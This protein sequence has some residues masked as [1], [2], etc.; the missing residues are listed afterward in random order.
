MMKRDRSDWFSCMRCLSDHKEKV[1]QKN[2]LSLFVLIGS[3]VFPMGA[4]A[5]PSLTLITTVEDI[6]DGDIFYTAVAFEAPYRYTLI[7]SGDTYLSSITV[8]DSV[9]GVVGAV[10][11][12]V[13]P[14]E[15]N[16]LTATNFLVNASVTNMGVAVGNPTDS[17]GADLPA[18]PDVTDSDEA[19]VWIISPDITLIVTADDATQ[20]ETGYTISGSDV[21]Y[22]YTVINSGNTYLT[23][24]TVTD[25][26]VGVVGT[27]S[28]PVS[29][30]ATNVLLA[31][32]LNVTAAI[33]NL[34]VV[35]GHPTD[36]GGG[37]LYTDSGVVGDISDTDPAVV[38][39]ASPGLSLITTA[40]DAADGETEYI[41]SGSNVLYRYTVI[42]SGDTYLSSMSVTDSVVGVV[43][44]I[45][46]PVA[47]GSTNVLLATNLN[48]TASVTNQGVAIANPTDSGGVD[49]P[50]LP[51]VNDSDSAFVALASPALTLITTAGNAADGAT[52]YII[53]GS[54]VVY[55]Y[56]LIN[57]GDTYLSSMTVTDSVVGVVGSISGPVAPG[58]T[59]VLLATNLNV[60]AS[61]TNQ[62]VAIANP[63]DSGGV[64]LPS[65]TNV[66]AMDMAIVEFFWIDI[67]NANET[68]PF[69]ITDRV[70]GG[71]STNLIGTFVWTNVLTGVGGTLP[72]SS[73]WQIP[74]PVILA[75]GTN[76]IE[77]CGT[78][79]AGEQACDSV[80]IIRTSY[81]VFTNVTTNVNV[82]FISW[83]FSYV[84]GTFFG[85][86]EICNR[87]G[88]PKK[89]LE[90]YW[91]L[92]ESN[93]TEYLMAPDGIET[94]SG[95][96]YVDLSTQI[97]A[98]L[99]GIGNGDGYLD[100]DECVVVTNIEYYSRL[101]EEPTGLVWAI[102]AD[103]PI[104]NEDT[105]G[106]GMLDAWE[107]GHALNPYDPL[108][109]FEDPD[110]D[111]HDNWEEAISGTDPQNCESIF[112]IQKLTAASDR[113]VLRWNS[114][115]SR[116]YSVWGCSN[117]YDPVYSLLQNEIEATPPVNIW[118]NLL[119]CPD[120]RFF[121]IDVEH[122]E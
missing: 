53:S 23:S 4:V 79:A 76:V 96:P 85:T 19:I 39:L 73:S 110:Q 108:D 21:V 88:S 34:G 66:M 63:T 97:V 44:S 87:T 14:G 119:P 15:T 92:M 78:N 30:G 106:D 52:E 84:T 93:A 22:R 111:G 37:D 99:S 109:A 33:T 101:R 107:D 64:D 70:V 56:T 17:G 25:S 29:F 116:W 59:N 16:V 95:F 81:Q 115:S 113:R 54:N 11:G 20:G 51:D 83:D 48:V 40:G 28:G 7:N 31:T 102:W 118:T 36:S 67:T 13:A 57:S 49:L 27:I 104:G 62:G 45:G 18:E 121:K 5:A 47:P 42:N 41:L 35:V 114:E 69:S 3:L 74:S 26:V 75:E 9:V 46:G 82:T 71:T 72:A 12:P 50:S 89:L 2:Y 38:A 32:N 120:A 94:H 122:R 68:V 10:A 24:I 8:T 1:I 105:D 61:V 6:D 80:N 60:T 91:F 65:L 86:I 55:Q 58:S 77:V 98:Q 100:P 112:K 117:L 103:P 90:P 43:G